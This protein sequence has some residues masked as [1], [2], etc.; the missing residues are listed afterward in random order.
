M[1]DE[2]PLLTIGQLAGRTAASVRS[3]RYW[4]DIGVLTPER[5]SAGGYRLYGADAV[6]RLELIR[7]LRQ[8]GLSLEEVRRVVRGETTAARVAADHIAAVDAQIRALKVNRA[9]LSVI[10]H[11]GSTTEETALVNKLARLSTDE[12]RKIVED[13]MKEVSGELEGAP[14][15]GERLRRS[16]LE[17][18]DNPSAEQVDA[19][20]E[21]AELIRDP[22][23]RTRM[24]RMLALNAPGR[25]GSSIWFTRHVVEVVGEAREREVAPAGHEASAV[26]TRLFHDADRAEVLAAL[27]AGLAADVRRFHR[28]LSLVR[29]RRP[30]QAHQEDYLWLE[31]ALQ[32]ELRHGARAR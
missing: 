19:W 25:P 20:L 7:S 12:R 29:G 32:A 27:R 23:F 21:L 2:E 9:V 4:S 18:P 10:A 14:D 24:R 15:M 30:R 31:Q 16:P 3:I 11:R 22:D 26:L 5:R 13:F 1:N 28:L 6:L 17:L 8:L